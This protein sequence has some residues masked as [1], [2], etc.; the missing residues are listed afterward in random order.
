MS[1]Y[2][3]Q[4]M[5]TQIIDPVLSTNTRCVFRIPS[6]VC[7][8]QSVALADLAFTTTG[9]LEPIDLTMIGGISNLIKTISLRIGGT[10]VDFNNFVA[11]TNTLQNLRTNT[12]KA[13]SMDSYTKLN[14][15]DF[16][17]ALVKSTNQADEFI[18]CSNFRNEPVSGSANSQGSLVYLHELLKFFN[19]SHSLDASQALL[20][21]YAFKNS[22]I[23]L[24]IEWQ[25]DLGVLTNNVGVSITGVLPPKLILDAMDTSAPIYEVLDNFK[26]NVTLM[27]DRW[28]TES[29]I[30]NQ[31][32]TE[33]AP[34]VVRERLNQVNGK[35]VKRLCLLTQSNAEN[36]D[37]GEK[38]KSTALP[39]ENINLVLNGQQVLDFR[40]EGNGEKVQ[41]FVNAWGDYV[42]PP[43][44]R[45]DVLDGADQ[46]IKKNQ[47]LLEDGVVSPIVGNA[48]LFGV[49]IYQVVDYLELDFQYQKGDTN[50][51]VTFGGRLNIIYETS[52]MVT[53]NQG[54]FSVTF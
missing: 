52:N 34:V 50:P 19:A 12:T 24:T 46:V 47:V 30:Y 2:R 40:S 36:A 29:L 3:S 10:Q 43:F 45:Y 26:G 31:P 25:T 28:E 53:I 20:P 33:F 4:F 38:T 23:E 5:S 48:S 13:S 14:A 54:V 42:L 44:G 18:V 32:L 15:L 35:F 11:V 6:V 51:A 49:G 41:H 17:H 21:L 27:Y 8:K 16:K 39:N 7:L 37:M 22:P 9:S 1:E